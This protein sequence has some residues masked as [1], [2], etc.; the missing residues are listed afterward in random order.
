MIAEDLKMSSEFFLFLMSNVCKK[1]NSEVF[2]LLKRYSHRNPSIIK[3]TQ[4]KMGVIQHLAFH[5]GQ[6][7]SVW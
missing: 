4:E 3:T 1:A 6:H 7:Y 2:Q 5:I